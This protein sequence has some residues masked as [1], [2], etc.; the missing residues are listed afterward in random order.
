MS[1][2][3][4]GVMEMNDNLANFGYLY[5]IC[6]GI[7]LAER[8]SIPS[9][10]MIIHNYLLI[11][12]RNLIR[13]RVFIG[14]N[15]FGL[16][17]A[18]ACC[19]IAYINLRESLSFDAHHNNTSNI[20]R[21]GSVRKVMEEERLN[22]SIPVPL[23]EIIKENA[24]DVSA[25]MRFSPSFSQFR[26]NDEFINAG[27]AYIDPDLLKVFTFEFIAGKPEGLRNKSAIFLS[28]RMSKKLFGST[29]AL[30]QTVHQYLNSGEVREFEVAG[31]FKDQPNTSSFKRDAYVNYDN[32]FYEFLSKNDYWVNYNNVF[33]QLDDP[34]AISSLEK[35]L[36]SY[37]EIP[38]KLEKN[39]PIKSF[40]FEPFEGMAQRDGRRNINGAL[41][42][43]FESIDILLFLA[44]LM[45]VVGAVSGFYP[46]LYVS[47][48][49]PA[50]ILKGKLEIGGISNFTRTLLFL[51]FSISVLALFFS[52]SFYQ[53]SVYQ[54][55]FDFGFAS[56]DLVIAPVEDKTEFD[57]LRN[58]LVA[59][60]DVMSITGSA[61]H[62]F[63][64]RITQMV[65]FNNID[66]TADILHV[67]EGYPSTMGFKL[68]QGRDFH[69]ASEND[70]YESV[71]ITKNLAEDV[72]LD[73]ALEKT[74]IIDDT[75]K[76]F[77]I[78]IIDDVYNYGMWHKK[79]GMILRHTD[80][81]NYRKAIIRT[82]P[83]KTERVNEF[84]KK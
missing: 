62:I 21:I 83:G 7:L 72:G 27:L 44:L 13:N 73:N 17:I 43:I 30:G 74:I 64:N 54:K 81:K 79:G 1:D 22:A 82:L 8:K 71:I 40:Y 25:V 66:I 18:I 58:L 14:I 39:A 47:K 61:H 11:S 4:R 16:A 41:L 67:G 77:V 31:L 2:F 68:L 59:Q 65:T 10:C 56:N 63:S 70:K 52:I 49:Q 36:N 9:R 76:V 78:G 5:S 35:S 3:G 80:E 75:T 23:G 57:K 33:V 19:L 12:F 53:N 38:N 42:K 51:Q 50:K 32:Y 24:E 20:Y 29:N 46:A 37:I 55:N 69:S 60:P 15:V 84:I 28:E 34:S 6:S 45:V 26:I 48:Y